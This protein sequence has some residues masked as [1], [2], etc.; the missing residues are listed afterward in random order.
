MRIVV[1][2]DGSTLAESVLPCVEDL[3]RRLSAEVRF[4]QVVSLD[5]PLIVAA[6]AG[7]SYTPRLLALE[8]KAETAKVG[9]YLSHLAEEWASRGTTARWEVL[10]GDPAR[11]IVE[12][13]AHCDADLIAMS[14]HGRSGVAR[15]ILGSVAERVVRE[16]RVPVLLFR[17]S[18]LPSP[19][20]P[21]AVPAVA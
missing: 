7:R 11:C 10:H 6:S 2:L 4:V 3:A 17:P 9:E 14:T 1:P 15:I 8:L 18:A 19:G 5:A 20:R 21:R 12:Y 13:A 16:A